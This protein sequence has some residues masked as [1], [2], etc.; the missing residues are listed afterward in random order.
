MKGPYI[1]ALVFASLIGATIYIRSI[2]QEISESE[3]RRLR[4][5]LLF[6]AFSLVLIGVLWEIIF[7]GGNWGFDSHRGLLFWLILCELIVNGIAV[8]TLLRPLVYLLPVSKGDPSNINYIGVTI[9]FALGLIEALL[10]FLGFGL[11]LAP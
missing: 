7:F 2:P 9:G 5:G 10:S 6:A 3:L 8:F 4:V 1:T 11:M